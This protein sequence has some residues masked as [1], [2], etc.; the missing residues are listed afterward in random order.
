MKKIELKKISLEDVKKKI[1]G[2]TQIANLI[3]RNYSDN[4]T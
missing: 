3:Y 2:L 4:E 1:K